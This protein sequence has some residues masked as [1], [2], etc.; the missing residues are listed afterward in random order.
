MRA[1]KQFALAVGVS[2]HVA[3]AVGTHIHGCGV[4]AFVFVVAGAAAPRFVAA[5]V[6]TTSKKRQR[7]EEGHTPHRV[8][9]G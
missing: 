1:L 5:G 2:T 8:E 7:Q 3:F 6:H 9:R 4:Y